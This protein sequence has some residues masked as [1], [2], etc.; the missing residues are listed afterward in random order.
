MHHDPNPFDEGA[1]D[2]NPYSVSQKKTLPLFIGDF[3]CVLW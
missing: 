1:A 3:S 2:D